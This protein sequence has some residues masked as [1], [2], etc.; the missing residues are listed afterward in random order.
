[1]EQCSPV[2]FKVLG[3]DSSL[4][5]SFFLSLARI[6][7]FFLSNFSCTGINRWEWVEKFAL[8]PGNGIALTGFE[9]LL[10]GLLR[11]VLTRGQIVEIV[12]VRSPDLE[13][14]GGFTFE[15]RESRN[16]AR[17]R[18]ANAPA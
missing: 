5:P 10:E 8:S 12:V 3:S 2:F 14:E 18:V 15:L 11:L 9:P 6:F 13:F 4:I 17:N 7:F 16:G 1:M